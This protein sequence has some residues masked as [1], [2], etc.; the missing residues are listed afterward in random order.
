[1]R[2]YA[3]EFT[4]FGTCSIAGVFLLLL[5]RFSEIYRFYLEVF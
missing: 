2:I 3:Y 5:A 4:R 1:M